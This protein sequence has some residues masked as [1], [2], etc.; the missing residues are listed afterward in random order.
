MRSP[1]GSSRSKVCQLL[2]SL[3]LVWTILWLYQNAHAQAFADGVAYLESERDTITSAANARDVNLAVQTLGKALHALQ[4][5][6]SHSNWVSL[7]PAEQ[8]DIAYLLLAPTTESSYRPALSSN[9]QLTGFGN[10]S[11]LDPYP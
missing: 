2:S 1:R 3:G 6:F 9:L 4:D 11:P 10:I 7:T 5:F 8:A